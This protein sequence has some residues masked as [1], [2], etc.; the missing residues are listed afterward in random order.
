[1][2]KTRV[3]TEV[4]VASLLFVVSAKADLFTLDSHTNDFSHPVSINL[5][6]GTYFVIPVAGAWSAWPSN[7]PCPDTDSNCPRGWEPDFV[8]DSPAIPFTVVGQSFWSTPQLAFD[9]RVGLT[10]TLP[11]AERVDFSLNDCV[12][13][14]ADN[15]GTLTL[16][17]SRVPEP[18]ALLLTAFVIANVLVLL[19]RKRRTPR[20]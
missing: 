11:G 3:R 12:G 15:R 9:H 17:V 10:F 20:C 1:M 6:A 7:S 4:L 18:S 5:A 2:S 13:C 14:L 8:I 19:Q 16:D